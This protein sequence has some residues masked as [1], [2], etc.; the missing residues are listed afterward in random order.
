M[1]QIGPLLE[2]S[3]GSVYCLHLNGYAYFGYSRDVLG[4]VAKVVAELKRGSFKI[5][6][7]NGKALN[8]RVFAEHGDCQDI[9]TLKLR[10]QYLAKQWEAEGW[11]LWNPA[12]KSL[13]KY[14]VVSRIDLKG[15]SVNVLLKGSG[16]GRGKRAER[17]LGVFSSI[18]EASEFIGEFYSPD[19]NPMTLPVYSANSRTRE[20]Y[21]NRLRGMM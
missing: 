14:E 8:L 20:W 15:K 1:Q 7:M 13:L 12:I 9:E 17:V 21:G 5:R 4:A 2:I 3:I 19:V 18:G 6:G 10:T 11:K 16:K